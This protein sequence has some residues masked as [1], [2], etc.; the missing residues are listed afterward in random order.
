MQI[1]TLK[2][3]DKVNDKFFWLLKHFTQNEVEIIQTTEE[4][5]SKSENIESLGGSLNKYAD[6]SK[7]GLEDN[8]WELH[9]L[10]KY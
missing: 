4:Q 3:D 9:I 10:D 5:K 2:V 6:I 7:I 1:I 8:A